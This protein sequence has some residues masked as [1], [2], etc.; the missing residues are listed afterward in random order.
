MEEILIHMNNQEVIYYLNLFNNVIQDEN[1]FN[2]GNYEFDKN[3]KLKINYHNLKIQE[4]EYID[5][6][7]NVK[8]YKLL[9]SIDSAKKQDEIQKDKIILIK[10]KDWEDNILLK[11]NNED[12]NN[13]AKRFNSDD[14]GSFKIKDKFLIINW[15]NYDKEYF[16]FNEDKNFYS[17]Y[18]L[19]KNNNQIEDDVNQIEDDVNQIEDD[20]NQIEDDVNQIKDDVNQI[21][22]DVNQIKDDVNQI[23]EKIIYIKNNTWEDNCTLNFNNNCFFRNNQT[24]EKALFKVFNHYLFIKW[25]KWD[26]ELFYNINDIFYNNNDFIKLYTFYFIDETKHYYID[27]LSIF[28]ENYFTNYLDSYL[29]TY[30]IKNERLIIEN[31]NNKEIP[32]QF[33]NHNDNFYEINNKYS[34]ILNNLDIY[35]S[36]NN[37][38]LDH[39]YEIIAYYKKNNNELEITY[40]NDEI[41]YLKIEN[42]HLIQINHCDSISNH[43]ELIFNIYNE[44]K[45]KKCILTNNELKIED[46]KFNYLIDDESYD[47]YLKESQKVNQYKKLNNIYYLNNDYTFLKNIN[48]NLKIYKYFNEYSSNFLNEIRCDEKNKIIYNQ[49]SLEDN[50]IFL[51]GYDL[52]IDEIKYNDSL[53]E[54]YGFM[55]CHDKNIKSNTIFKTLNI[56]N[57]RNIN[58]FK[59]NQNFYISN[60]KILKDNLNIFIIDDFEDYNYLNAIF[61]F[62]N[63]FKNYYIYINYL[64]YDLMI[65]FYIKKIIH[66]LF[67]HKIISTQINIHYLNQLKDISE[68][69]MI[70]YPNYYQ[71]NELKQ[72]S[73][74][75]KQLLSFIQSKNDILFIIIIYYLCIYKVLLK[76]NNNF[77][78]HNN[79]I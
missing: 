33:I 36:G 61:N 13:I 44:N 78:S 20:V 15:D 41:I 49:F 29:F 27:K 52:L 65:Y 21:K 8:N 69:N 19:K 70:D 50:Y 66:L 72:F 9:N 54:T 18:N 59:C 35:L 51:N 63:E 45:L 74:I 71:S 77:K 22:D 6:I 16:L 46:I 12:K 39:N 28:D 48:F 60:M 26:N 62:E 68:S 2:I 5:N 23:E 75:L 31:K 56:I 30:K 58:D 73:E 24:D 37:T 4:F 55:I 42:K 11:Y 67:S 76:Q 38:I 43:D 47:L 1:Y 17:Y 53:F 57:F 25:E 34:F 79:L 3:N 64:K 40:L 10:H 14:F 7:N 32:M